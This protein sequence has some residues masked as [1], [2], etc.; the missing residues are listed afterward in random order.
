MPSCPWRPGKPLFLEHEENSSGFFFYLKKTFLRENF[1]W[2][3]EVRT[4]FL[5]LTV[6]TTGLGFSQG[7]LISHLTEVC[8]EQGMGYLYP[9]KAGQTSHAVTQ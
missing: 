4:G 7:T 8:I 3:R 2:E 6:T 9:V 5:R 1:Q